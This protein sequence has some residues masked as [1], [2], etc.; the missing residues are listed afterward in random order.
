MELSQSKKGFTL[1]V[2]GYLY[3]RG[4]AYLKVGG[5][6]VI[7][8]EGRGYLKERDGLRLYFLFEILIFFTF[9]S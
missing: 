5:G 8:S 4:C 6:G 9:H 3:V 1:K 2:R 7:L